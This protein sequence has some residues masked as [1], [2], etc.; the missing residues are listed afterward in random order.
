MNEIIAHYEQVPESGRLE[1]GWGRLELARTQELMLRRLPAPPATV[2][3]IGGGTGIYSAWLSGLGYATH[4]IDLVPEHARRAQTS[5]AR[6]TV[7]IGDA[8]ALAHRNCSVDA[9]L[10]FGPL[11]HLTER[12]GRRAALREALRVLRPGGVLFAAAISRFAPLL[13]GMISQGLGDPAFVHILDEDL[14]TG[15]HRNDTGNPKYFTTAFLHLPAELEE[16]VREAGFAGVEILPV[17]GPGILA[18]D[19]DALWQ[20]PDRREQLLELVRTVEQEPSLL[21]ASLHLLAVAHKP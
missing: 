19:F 2:L 16:E 20:D 6:T 5:S 12:T 8:R 21:G 13:D 7:E 17:E 10:L 3:D 14:R 11:Y 18:P 4:L 1:A 15:Q 9:A